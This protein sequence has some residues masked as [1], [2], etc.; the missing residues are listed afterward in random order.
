MSEA[1]NNQEQPE[2]VAS[3]EDEKPRKKA[4]LKYV[5]KH[6][7]LYKVIFVLNIVI[8]SVYI[9]NVIPPFVELIKPFYPYPDDP[10][11]VI[12]MGITPL[13]LLMLILAMQYEDFNH[14]IAISKGDIEEVQKSPPKYI[15]YRKFDSFKIYTLAAAPVIHAIYYALSSVPYISDVLLFIDGMLIMLLVMNIFG[16]PYALLIS[17]FVFIAK[18][19]AKHGH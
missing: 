18:I 11:F 19:I 17:V 12:S 13:F 3:S 1:V 6:P 9:L 2:V 8:T 10:I 7:I 14:V 15:N 5:A 16:L 4:K